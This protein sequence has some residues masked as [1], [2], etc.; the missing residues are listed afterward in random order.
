MDGPKA[1]GVLVAFGEPIEPPSFKPSNVWTVVF[2]EQKYR[3][4]PK[5]VPIGMADVDYLAVAV[6][7]GPLKMWELEVF[8]TKHR[9][10]LSIA[11][12]NGCSGWQAVLNFE[13]GFS[14]S[15]LLIP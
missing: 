14:C 1:T 13:I 12:S 11:V 7:D 10:R 5:E 8:I 15:K 4:K 2:Y 9:K 6:E 3:W